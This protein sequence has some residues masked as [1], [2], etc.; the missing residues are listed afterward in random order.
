M[1]ADVTGRVGGRL[2][3]ARVRLLRAGFADPA[4]AAALLA[5][6]VLA[7]YLPAA[8]PAEAPVPGPHLPGTRDLAEPGARH[9]VL[10][11]AL[12]DTADPDLALLTLVRLAQACTRHSQLPDAAP[13]P[14]TGR[15]DS[16]HEPARLLRRLLAWSP[17]G[18]SGRDREGGD[19]DRTSTGSDSTGSGD[20]AAPDSAPGSVAARAAGEHQRR[21]L[22]VLG[23]SQA[24]GDFLVS[25]PERLTALAPARAWQAPTQ[26]TTHQLL[27]HAVT[28]VLGAQSPRCPGPDSATLSRATAALRCAYRDR[29]LA[30]VA[31]DLTCEQPVDHVAVVGTRMAELADAALDAGLLV[32]RAAVG[33]QADSVALAVIAMGKTGARELNYVS[34]V[35]VIY[36]VGAPGAQEAAHGAAAAGV[37]GHA[38][39]E[40]GRP[41]SEEDLVAVGTQV[42]T[43]LARVVSA[44]SAEPPLWPLDTALRP[45]GKDG[46]L[47]RTL[48]SHLVYYQRWAASWEFQALLKARASAGDRRLGAA[49]V[50]A[51]SALVWEATRREN[52][53]EDARAMRQRVERES[54]PLGERDRRIKLGPGGLRDVEFTVQL[55]QLVHGRS[56]TSLRARGTLE[57]LELLG[58]GGYVARQDAAAMSDCYKALRLLEHRSQLYR[59]RRTH[60]LPSREEDLRRI[61]RGLHRSVADTDSLWRVFRELRRRV[62]ALHEEIYYRPLL[63]A[64]ASLSA[65]EMA[66]SPQAARER[67]AAFGYVDAEGALR[68]IQALTEGVSRRAAIQRQLLPVII[69]WI[70]QGADPDFGLLSFRRLSEAVGGSH[71][72]LAMLR[73][74]PVAARRLCHVLSC[75]HW[76]CERLAE[77]PEAI[78]WLDDDAELLPRR[79]EALHEE[80]VSVLR[81]R[82]L[83]GP[84]E[85][86]L[87]KQALEA[88]QAVVRV[89]AREEVRASL[90]DCLDAISPE[91]T[92]TILTGATDAVL[93]GALC[94]ATGLV[95]ALREGAP[96]VAQGPGSS[97]Q[98]PTALAEHAVIAMGRLGGSEVGYASDAD[99]LFVHRSRPGADETQAAQEADAVARWTLRLLAA[100][101]PHPLEVDTGLRPEGRQGPMSR[102]LDSYADYYGR[103][104]AVWERQAL[105]R[106]RAC[107]GDSGLG[108]AFEDLVAGLRWAEGGLSGQDRR[109]IRRIKARME[110]ERLPRAVDPARHLKL[111]PGGLSDVEWC[112]QVLQLAH[113]DHV[114]GLRTTSTLTALQEA[115][116]ADLLDA[117]DAARLTAAWLLA[118]RLRAAI[119]LG[120]GRTSG[121]R[122]EVLPDAVR[123][124]RLVGRLIG[125][126]GG[127]ERELEDLYR[128]SARHARAV[129]ERVLFGGAGGTGGA[130]TT[131]R[132]V[133]RRGP[134]RGAGSTFV[135]P[136]A[137]PGG[138]GGR[139][140]AGAG[141][142]SGERGR[143][144]PAQRRTAGPVSTRV[145][146]GQGARTPEGGSLREAGAGGTRTAGSR[147]APSW[148]RGPGPGGGAAR[149]LGEGPYPWS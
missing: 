15:T 13:A 149:R 116:A 99:V 85:A 46:A 30:I 12:A 134:H 24:L 123:D 110:T 60:D 17:D 28:D 27:R 126:E 104:A 90:A 36:V 65:D 114:E 84:D 61:G 95:I 43:E 73:D 132:V 62:R 72:Y 101:R 115:A 88:V 21:L 14:G 100:A 57:A 69:G 111:G 9:E 120:T 64:A 131:G 102:S 133:S 130:A 137:D 105:L 127:H 25:H 7:D 59:L 49:Y 80:T 48:D 26:P 108:R 129:T 42:A 71:W 35:D 142:A 92:S 140:Q 55:L 74:S 121:P 37:G 77:L 94:V 58:R 124:I 83:S 18:D 128:R 78:A 135:L 96:A 76:V 45:E 68:H 145:V 109:E 8:G 91:R 106:A 22:A 41:L 107:A 98:W 143:A 11:T 39:P 113:A 23:H 136:D 4:R 52:F 44:T 53:V 70:G 122:R 66:L 75:A 51:V 20:G 125:L 63:G 1:E 148:R 97:L 118:S 138:L 16:R 50:D 87:E 33:P 146:P 119:V 93:G 19:S 103:W 10:L 141:P 38:G 2:P 81:R 47:V 112:A 117:E 89:R 5:D 54:A 86:A 67:L 40:S 79:R 139:G 82:P 32:A 147:P 29:L 144:V 56:D 6:P 34:D 31:D 3:S